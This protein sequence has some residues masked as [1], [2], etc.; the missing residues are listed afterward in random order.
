MRLSPI[1][2][3]DLENGVFLLNFRVKLFLWWTL[4]SLQPAWI[5][6]YGVYIYIR[7]Y[8]NSTTIYS[9]QTF[10]F[11]ADCSR[12]CETNLEI[13]KLCTHLPNHVVIWLPWQDS[14]IDILFFLNKNA[15]H[16]C[17]EM[18]GEIWR[19]TTLLQKER[20]TY[21]NSSIVKF[22]ISK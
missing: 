22:K 14:Q 9:C 15:T 5:W 4:S 13:H 1:T 8:I 17:C 2:N 7:R 16:K 20:G 12:T 3:T 21:N 18:D 6:S 11:S 19:G 10:Y